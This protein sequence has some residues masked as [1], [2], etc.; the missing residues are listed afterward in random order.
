MMPVSL[1]RSQLVSQLVEVDPV[2]VQP[3]ENVSKTKDLQPLQ[4]DQVL[5]RL[6]EIAP[7]LH[8]EYGVTRLGVFGSVARDE[9][10]AFSDIDVVLELQTPDLFTMVEIKEDLEQV[11]QCSIDVVRYRERMNPYLKGRIDREAVYV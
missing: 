4:R 3:M 7:Q 8:C 10:T 2:Y 5:A 9:A 6:R 1:H 11:F